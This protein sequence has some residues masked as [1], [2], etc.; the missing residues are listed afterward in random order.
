[1]PKALPLIS[2]C[3][4]VTVKPSRDVQPLALRGVL[5]VVHTVKNLLTWEANLLA[6][7]CP[8]YFAVNN[9]GLARFSMGVPMS[10]NK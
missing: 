1:V 3:V 6:V 10:C 9:R 5:G 4:L 2:L 8:V 7:R